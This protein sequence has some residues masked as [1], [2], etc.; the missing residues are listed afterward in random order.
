M[1]SRGCPPLLAG[2]VCVPLA[3]STDA[4]MWEPAQPEPAWVVRDAL[5]DVVRRRGRALPAV[6]T[7]KLAT[8]AAPSTATSGLT[9]SAPAP[10]A[11]ERTDC[12]CL[13]RRGQRGAELC[14]EPPA[15]PLEDSSVFLEQSL[16]LQ[17]EQW[18]RWQ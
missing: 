10:G 13:P 9:R 18:L 17:S 12:A 7:G 8:S 2:G 16:G 11:R 5:G 4:E 1:S 15:L 6:E 3:Q 14:P